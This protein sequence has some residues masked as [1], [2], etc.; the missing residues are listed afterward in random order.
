MLK[1][2]TM[3]G[4]EV[5][6]KLRLSK[7]TQNNNL[8]IWLDVYDE[9]EY[10]GPWSSLTV[11]LGEDLALDRAYIDVNNNG[12]G[13]VDWL[14]SLGLGEVVGYGY[15]GFCKYPLFQFNVLRLMSLVEQAA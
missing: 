13:I 9:G 10:A 8:A 7:Y 6:V 1:L 4:T 3:W 5:D 11:N 12:E 14:T 15:S 2:K